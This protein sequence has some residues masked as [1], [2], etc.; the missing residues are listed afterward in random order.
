MLLENFW[1]IKHLDLV[2]EEDRCR[3]GRACVFYNDKA[4]LP[5][6]NHLELDWC[7]GIKCN[8]LFALNKIIAMVSH[9][10]CVTELTADDMKSVRSGGLMRGL[11][12]DGQTCDNR[13]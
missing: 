9:S 5:L 1:K 10:H 7:T 2:L 13:D 6:D 8:C 4:S 11:L 3:R 12:Y